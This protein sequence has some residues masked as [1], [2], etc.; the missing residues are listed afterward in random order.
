MRIFVAGASGVIGMRLVPLL[1]ADGHVVAGLTRSPGK[2]ATLRELGAE[3]VVCDVFDTEA[4]TTAVTGFAPDIV[5]DQLTDLPD[6]EA[7]IA[8]Y[9]ARNGRIR[10]E[11][12]RNL[13]AA[14][15]AAA[16]QRVITQSI[17]WE[18]PTED[19]RASTAAHERA[20][21]QAGGVV[22][23]YGQFWGPGTYYPHAPPGPPR[24]HVD[25]AARQTLLALTVPSG[26][27]IVA[28][29]RAAQAR[30]ADGGWRRAKAP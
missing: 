9:G 6:S 22:I 11:G 1:T 14:A 2:A 7:D 15:A 26:L 3:P 29:D 13:L 19:G 12:T 25:D 4:L 23:R 8:S 18:L 17:S 10:T 28:D 20:V 5:L 16:A 30:G 24:I 21:L 27:T